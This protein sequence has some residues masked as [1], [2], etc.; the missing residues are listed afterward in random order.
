[1]SDGA[2]EQSAAAATSATAAAPQPLRIHT[3]SLTDFRAFPGPAPAI[4]E[5]D[6]KNLL[7][8]GENGAGKS[9]LFHALHDFFSMKPSRALASHKNIFSQQPEDLCKVS[10]T[11]LGAS[12]QTL[13]WTTTRHPCNYDLKRSV[14]NWADYFFAGTD[15][16]VVDAARKSACLD[17]KS[18]LETNFKHGND[19]INLFDLAVS[20]LLR[21]FRVTVAGGTESTISILWNAI[22]QA[23]GDALKGTKSPRKEQKVRDACVAWLP[24]TPLFARPWT[25]YCPRPTKFC[26]LWAG[27][28]LY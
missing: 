18:L 1:M 21:D 6:G 23:E 13:D 12:A 14:A 8:Y 2:V 3:I 25:V 22:K 7:V 17:Y 20:S 9:S 16:Q 28:T 5:L 4:F 24:S 26:K 27:A 11:F 19:P 10:V 15:P